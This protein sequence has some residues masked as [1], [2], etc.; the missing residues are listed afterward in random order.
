MTV[1]PF[2]SQ[3]VSASEPDVMTE[4]L[5]ATSLGDEDAFRKLYDVMAGSV[6]GLVRRVLRDS[7]QSEEVAQDVLVEVWRLAPRFDRAKGSGKTWILT[8]A[9]RRAVDR[10]RSAQSASDRD[11]RYSVAAHEPDQ[12]TVADAVET[13]LEQRQVKNALGLLTQTQRSAIELA[14]YKGYTHNEVAATLEIPL[15]TAK[16]RLRDG[17]IHLRDALGVTS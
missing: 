12:D 4:L 5:V 7:A 16:T 1:I 15:G 8:M 14:Y 6:F 3:P 11:Y 2:E 10:V 17:L 13:R 9:H